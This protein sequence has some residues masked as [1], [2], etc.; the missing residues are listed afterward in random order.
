M[1]HDTILYAQVLCQFAH[2]RKIV[3]IEERKPWKIGDKKMAAGSGQM[4]LF[5]LIVSFLEHS[6]QFAF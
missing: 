2:C 4:D 5:V 3:F 6:E 1:I